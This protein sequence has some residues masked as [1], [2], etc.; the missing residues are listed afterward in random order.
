MSN[1]D[2]FQKPRVVG[3]EGPKA[4]PIESVQTQEERE[5]TKRLMEKMYTYGDSVDSKEFAEWGKKCE[6]IIKQ[7][8]SLEQMLKYRLYHAFIGGTDDE[9]NSKEPYFDFEG[10]CSIKAMIESLPS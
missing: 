9:C 2:Q 6:E 1:P 8:Y 3:T 5:S 10:K 7:K 4:G